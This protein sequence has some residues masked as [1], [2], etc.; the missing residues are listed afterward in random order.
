MKD[1]EPRYSET[2]N[3]RKFQILKDTL[4]LGKFSVRRLKKNSKHWTSGNETID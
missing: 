3:D 1:I 4:Y 2:L